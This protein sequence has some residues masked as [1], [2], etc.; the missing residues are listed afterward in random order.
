MLNSSLLNQCGGYI[1]GRW[2]AA[3]SGLTLA[4]HNPA[5][6]D[7]L[8]DVP[9]MS[10][11]ETQLA[12]VSASAAMSHV[13]DLEERRCWLNSI[14]EAILGNKEELGRIITLEQGKPL[15]EAIG[16]AAYAADFYRHSA[17][18]IDELATKTLPE[19]IRDSQ[20][21]I[22]HRPAGVAGLITPWNFP[23]AMLAKKLS[24]ALAAGCASVTKPAPQTPLSAIAFWSL[25][26][27]IG[28]PVGMANLVIGQAEPIGQ[29]LC[30]DPAVRVISFTGST[31]IGKL[32][33]AQ[34]A[35]HIKRLSLELGGNAP[36]IVFDDA[37]VAVA[38]DHL[39][40]NKFRASGQT[41]VCTNR[42]YAH[43]AIADDFVKKIARKVSLL[44]VGDG[45]DGQTDIGPL[46]NRAGFD[47]VAQHVKNAMDSGA[48]RLVGHDPPRPEHD[49]AAFYPP[50][51]LV[52]VTP[53]MLLSQEETFG[54]VIAVSTFE[55]EEVAVEQAN[56]TPYGLAAYLF[57]ADRARAQRIISQLRFGHVGLN[58]GMGPAAQA[59][60]GGMKQ[61]GIGREGGV[62]GLY[63]FCETQVVVNV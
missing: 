43:R 10:E 62:E 29:V 47:K 28:M 44:K 54:P 15:P 39:L 33:I 30:T 21:S 5:T 51:L 35:G 31:A 1:N 52:N 41:C 8:A 42:V 57:T 12:V 46:I 6:G 24:S 16:E 50:T 37:D 11:P 36:F 27:T 26:D 22:A 61:S 19:P 32:L 4:V 53:Q 7:H 9:N 13:A 14:A 38:T 34:T 48:H 60:F 17:Q 59:P 25:L 23:L 58:T 56:S 63:E 45:M 49:W 20:W 3:T 2:M 18:Q 55:D 40:A